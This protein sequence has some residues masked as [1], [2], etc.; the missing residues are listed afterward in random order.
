MFRSSDLFIIYWFS[1][2]I[3]EQ[4]LNTGT[5]KITMS[6]KNRKAPYEALT[7]IL[8]SLCV[9]LRLVLTLGLGIGLGLGLALGLGFVVAFN[10]NQNN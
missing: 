9:E 6:G 5:N 1:T 7:T 8:I 4:K 2:D 3:Q 10:C